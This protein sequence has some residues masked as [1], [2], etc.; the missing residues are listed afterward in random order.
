YF[1]DC[2]KFFGSTSRYVCA[3]LPPH[4]KCLLSQHKQTTTRGLV[5][6]DVVH[7]NANSLQNRF[8]DTHKFNELKY[9]TYLTRFDN[10]KLFSIH[11]LYLV[12]LIQLS[13]IRD[14]ND[15]ED[16]GTF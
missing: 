8:A 11:R 9:R 1:N 12:A 10:D 15:I 2:P 3:E 7:T 13:V 14:E 16:S 6:R 5:Y 4:H